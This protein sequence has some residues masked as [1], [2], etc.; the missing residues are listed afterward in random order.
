MKVDILLD[1]LRNKIKKA[2]TVGSWMQ[3]SNS[4]IAEILGDAGYDW[5]ALDL[6][7]GQFNNESL[8]D[9]FRALELNNTVPLARIAE[10]KEKDCKQ[11]LEAGAAGLIIPMINSAKDI[12]EAINFSCW[13]PKGKRGVG[14]S[15]ANL[16]GKY[17]KD[18]KKLAQ[19][20]F[21]IAMIE[22]IEGVNNLEEILSTKGL[23]GI[24]I[25][26]Y[27][28]S[29]SINKTGKLKDKQVKNL[30]N[31]IITMSK[32]YSIPCGLHQVE[33]KPEELKKL[34]KKGFKFIPYSIDT[35]LFQHYSQ[36]PVNNH[37]KSK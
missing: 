12:K 35:V 1:N 11:A 7:H 24:L 34:I 5:V 32:K 27:D 25:G 20:P 17:F 16:F 19:K 23:D 3:L 6:E 22:N 29:A 37:I 2:Y 18:Y 10:N 28:L 26:P 8:P 21:I 33:P 9:I 36:N 15:R 31:K 14:F 30:V 4:S 13:P